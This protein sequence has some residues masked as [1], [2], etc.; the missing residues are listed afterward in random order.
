M[1]VARLAQSHTQFAVPEWFVGDPDLHFFNLL[2]GGHSSL[3]PR[4]PI[5]NRTVKRVC[6][7]DSVPFAHA[8]VG[9]RQTIFSKQKTP[10]SRECR[11]FL[12]AAEGGVDQPRALR[13]AQYPLTRDGGLGHAL[14]GQQALIDG[15]EREA[16]AERA[17]HHDEKERTKA[18]AE[19]TKREIA[20]IDAARIELEMTFDTGDEPLRKVPT[21]EPMRGTKSHVQELFENSPDA[22]SLLTNLSS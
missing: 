12:L 11:G 13:P 6:A 19:I 22:S 21:M 10:G 14:D 17:R 9:Y 5:P 2:P 8:K 15:H 7:D 1:V 18:M 3:E 4:L 20:T 16:E